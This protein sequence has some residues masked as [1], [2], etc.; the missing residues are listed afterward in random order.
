MNDNPGSRSVITLAKSESF[1]C[2]R[3]CKVTDLEIKSAKMQCFSM[4]KSSTNTG[5]GISSFCR[6]IWP[7]T[8]E[9]PP[10]MVKNSIFLKVHSNINIKWNTPT[11]LYK[12]VYVHTREEWVVSLT[13]ASIE[14]IPLKTS[15][16]S[17][18][19]ALG[20][21]LKQASHTPIILWRSSS[22]PFSLPSNVI[23]APKLLK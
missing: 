10:K 23:S 3:C 15:S 12:R 4:K 13:R 1:P 9:N 21:S 20:W 22:I 16:I 8:A 7:N 11:A 2:A 14:T 18:G 5:V 17:D 6:D 19:L